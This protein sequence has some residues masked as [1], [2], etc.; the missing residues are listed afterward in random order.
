MMD[1]L[2]NQKLITEELEAMRSKINSEV[3]TLPGCPY[4][5]TLRVSRSVYIRCNPCGKNWMHGSDIFKHPHTKT[6]LPSSQET[7]DIVPPA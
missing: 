1:M 7:S 4:C 2:A 6:T 5:E 3:G